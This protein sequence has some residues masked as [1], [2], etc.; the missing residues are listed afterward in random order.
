MKSSIRIGLLGLGTVG[1]GVVRILDENADLIE[2]RIG[3]PLEIARVAVREA[4][5]ERGLS[6][7]AGVLTTDPFEVVRDPDI[8]I[9]V[10]LIGGSEPAKQLVL[11]AIGKGKHV[12]TANKA[13]LAEHGAAIRSAARTAR[14]NLGF[15]A[16]VGGG[17]PVIKTLRE[18]LAANHILSVYGILNG[19]CNYILTKMREE[20]R[21]FED[22]LREAQRAGYAESDPTFDVEGIDSAH[23]LAIL[24]N[25]SFGIPVAL[26]D[27][28]T[29]G[30]TQISPVDIEFG[31]EF[32]YTLKLLAIAKSADGEVE[33]RVHPTMVPDD[34]PIAKVGGVYNAVEIVGDVV[35]DVM[36]YG[37][38][39]GE[40]PTASAVISDIMDISRE[41][42]SPSGAK[43][44]VLLPPDG[45]T[46]RIRPIEAI[47]SPYYLRFMVDDLPGGLAQISG[48]L[49]SNNISIESVIQKGRKAGGTVP[50]VIMTHIALERDLQQALREIDELPCVSEKAVLLRVETEKA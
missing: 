34:D 49:G 13:L 31:R 43:A 39:A 3:V 47:S 2:R 23:K 32:G 5:R 35:E 46:G 8:D 7:E 44:P 37:K 30:I 17:I 42:Q 1:A 21:S 11:E 45:G 48:I 25:L 38:G 18:A 41:L 15:E 36:L 33:A 12:V 28:Y 19:T 50:L 40:R 10:E 9:V 16:S 22:V 4:G 20:N 27:I 26:G 14:V 24:V 29:E 6:V